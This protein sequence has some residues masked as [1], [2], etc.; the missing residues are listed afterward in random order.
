MGFDSRGFFK[1]LKES[2]LSKLSSPYGCGW[3]D[4]YDL[5]FWLL[6]NDCHEPLVISDGQALLTKEILEQLKDV[7]TNAG[8]GANPE[9]D[10]FYKEDTL[11]FIADA[12]L[13]I[14]LGGEVIYTSDDIEEDEEDEEDEY[15][16]DFPRPVIADPP[17]TITNS[18]GIKL[19]PIAAGTFMMGSPKKEKGHGDDRHQHEV[20]LTKDFYLGMTQVTQA[21]YEKVMGKNPS[22]FQGDKVAGRDS[23]EFPVVSIS[24]KDAVKFC[25]KL[26]EL[27]EEKKAG[28]VYRLPTEAEWEYACRAGSTTAFS[29]GESPKRLGD[30]AWYQDNSGS[31]PHPVA[32]KKPNAWGLYDMHGNVWEWCSD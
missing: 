23:S 22:Y 14:Q 8:F 28:R 32:L 20:T 31:R 5:D 24:W 27:P 13:T 11:T 16:D 18:I 15:E 6:G 25:N 17:G 1:G 9:I 12:L 19:V 21:Q 2:D 3:T 4:Y 26:S 10:K 7:I 29:F 30:Y